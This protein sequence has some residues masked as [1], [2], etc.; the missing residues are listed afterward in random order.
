M[1]APVK[2]GV[3]KKKES[4]S[5]SSSTS[6]IG[7]S[8]ASAGAAGK[9]MASLSSFQSSL[10]FKPLSMLPPPT[11]SSSSST[12]KVEEDRKKMPPP[13]L[14]VKPKVNPSVSMGQNN[15]RAT[16]TSVNAKGNKGKEREVVE[17]LDS[18][19]EDGSVEGE[20]PKDMAQ[21]WTELYAPTNETDLAPGKAR[22]QRVKTWL[23][24][25]LF[26]HPPGVPTPP[27]L[28]TKDK[29]RK[30]RRI[31]LL[32]GPAGS[33]KTTTVRLLAKDMGVDLIE[34]GEGVEEWNIGGGIERESSMT[35][36]TSFL[37]RHAY[38]TLSLSSQSSS[39]QSCPPVKP[40]IILLTSLPNLSHLPT[41]DAFHA[42][43]L[44]FCRTFTS[45]SCPIIIVHSDAGS[46]GRAEESWMDRERGGREGAL[47][48]VGKD[49]KD[50]PWCQEIDFLPLAPT[51][52]NKALMKVVQTAIPKTTQRPSVSTV[53]LIAL[54]CNGDL[55]SAINSLQ[56]LCSRKMND[57]SKKR[58]NREDDEEEEVEIGE[59][60]KKKGRGSRGGKGALLSV[61]PDL[62]AVLDAVTR[63]EQ[64]LGL[65]HALGKV[66]Y[67]KRLD[68][69]N[70]EDENKEVLE[71][72]RRLRPD[73][74]LPSHLQEFTRRKSL[75]QMESFVPTIPVDA[76][77]FALWIHQSLPSFCTDI[78]QV[79]SGIDELCA[80][81][82]MRTDDDIWQSSS[83]AIAYSLH[84]TIR[85]S[86][87]SL[88]S[89]VPRRSQKV[90][91]PQFFD[92]YRTERD[93]MAALDSATRY[94]MK[95]A[96]TSS[97]ILADGNVNGEQLAPWGGLVSTNVMASELVPMMVK[98]QGVTRKPLLP[99]S[100]QPLCMPPYS[101]YQAWQSSN[102]SEL[103]AKDSATADDD[104]EA[105][106]AG[107]DGM[108]YV[109]ATQGWDD[110]VDKEGKKEEEEE[111]LV[112]DDIDDWD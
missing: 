7:G 19:D 82:V 29:L 36:F 61:S 16:G 59:G 76:S 8:G 57:K 63:R 112:D 48:L 106:I 93:N 56:L 9:K 104:F 43:L 42:A 5:S 74:P 66:F 40:R 95:K 2:N 34:W 21:M 25:S 100:A 32:T 70:I 11:S 64:S 84:L 96:I 10:N 108:G 23:H 110:E 85:G 46:G 47:E 68:D 45:S 62:R 87:M 107:D 12:K 111:Y 89:P 22:I 58:K 54:S 27:K 20:K 81:D 98:I 31:L 13:P 28:S 17:V 52:L 99:S 101:A 69:P 92:A 78:E 53:Q 75:I 71:A 14:G 3:G 24:E 105:D 67:N 83:Q 90:I 91:K 102:N 86:L 79:S 41:R 97:N 35:K 51:F 1:V 94:T 109:H 72:V 50:G 65:F 60:T 55:R 44:D 49:V 39:S 18:D 77:S 30:Y 103:T 4:K 37:S 73:D 33:G 88:P 38:P 80:A 15:G 26:G 6:A